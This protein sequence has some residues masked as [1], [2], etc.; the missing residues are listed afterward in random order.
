MKH[1][2]ILFIGILYG[3]CVN[4]YAAD[5]DNTAMEKT[6]QWPSTFINSQGQRYLL[7]A[8][9]T[10][11]M[12]VEPAQF[13]DQSPQ[14]SVTVSSFYMGAFEVTKGQFRQFAEEVGIV[15]RYPELTA[16][17]DDP[18][19]ARLF[20]QTPNDYY[21]V[22]A[23][24][25]FGAEHYAQWLSKK[26]G[27]QYRLP[28]EAEWEYACRA[29]TTTMRWWG[30]KWFVGM[31]L[32][33]ESNFGR[34]PYGS[35]FLPGTAPANPWGFYEILGNSSEWVSDWFGPYGKEPVNDPAGPAQGKA[36]IIRGGWLGSNEDIVHSGFRIAYEANKARSGIRLVCVPNQGPV[37]SAPILPS[38]PPVDPAPT[39][40]VVRVELSPSVNLELVRLPAGHFHMGT[41]AEEFGH[42]R[43]EQ[44]LTKVTISY[45]Y[46]IGRYEVTQSQYELVMGN[47]PSRYVGGNHPV[48]SVPFFDAV[49]FCEQ[50]TTRER[51]A[52]RLSNYEIYRL[53]TEPEW[54]YACRAGTRTAYSFGDNPAL[55]SWYGWCDRLGGT[56]P[57]GEKRPNPWGIY[58]MHGN[59]Q[60]WCWGV[61][62]PLPGGEL[63]DPLRQ[64]GLLYKT[65]PHIWDVGGPERMVRGGGWCFAVHACR[66]AMR[67][68][69]DLRQGRP[70]I[71]F[72]LVRAPTSIET[73]RIRDP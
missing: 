61:P 59:V 62:V 36:K 7:V 4:N 17:H 44:P 58:D 13:K 12:G 52:G 6:D 37:P 19:M 28:T 15:D 32:V 27:R 57:V 25:W 49:K 64:P 67:Q 51:A 63:V 66:S 39:T 21:P 55:L 14:H 48:E 68:G 34:T 50:L 10:F 29:G 65:N 2:F 26:E 23:I 72:R 53:P 24:D 40:E 73:D 30:D 46:L 71:G 47:N 33:R 22:F 35:Y 31:A 69:F 43:L 45:S 5:G 18:E 70:F 20:A 16:K 41:P 1:F 11:M 3:A 9:G 38:E 56:H 54:E 8:S 60:E 42:G